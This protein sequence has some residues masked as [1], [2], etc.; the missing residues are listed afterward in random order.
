MSIATLATCTGNGLVFETDVS[1]SAVAPGYSAPEG[2]PPESVS[3]TALV[4][5]AVPVP[6]PFTVQAA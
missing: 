2:V 1:T 3:G 5:E 4:A 6:P